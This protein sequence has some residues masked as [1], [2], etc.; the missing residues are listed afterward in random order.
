MV[1]ENYLRIL[2]A[3]HTGFLL[4][5]R[6]PHLRDAVVPSAQPVWVGEEQWMIGGRHRGP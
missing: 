6:T 2:R 5:C 1:S 4:P 3:L